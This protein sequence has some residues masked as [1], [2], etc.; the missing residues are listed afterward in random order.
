M[1]EVN[2]KTTEERKPYVVNVDPVDFEQDFSGKFISSIDL[3]RLANEYFRA[4]FADFEGTTFNLEQGFPTMTLFFNH[5]ENVDGV[6]AV[7]RAGTKTVGSSVLDRTRRRD[8][9]LK[10]GDRYQITAD[11]IDIIKP[12][13]LPRLMNN[14]KPNWKQIVSDITDRNTQNMF[15]PMQ[16][17]QLT[18]VSGID[19]R[20]ICALIYGNKDE[21]GEYIDYGIEVK[22]DLN[23]RAGIMP[24]QQ[25]PNY[26]L[27]ITKAFNGNIQ[28]TYQKFGIN[29]AG[30]T[31]IRN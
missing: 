29:V 12:L 17:R 21:S 1:S 4:A 9:Q 2:E 8:N 19:P 3:C 31:I 25:A 30:S 18:R 22:G 7:E 14:G 24:G 26:A 20:R 6:F 13:L 16:P 28:K 23:I 27:A 10:E 5:A 15:Q 11:G